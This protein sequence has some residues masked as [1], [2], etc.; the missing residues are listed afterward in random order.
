MRRAAV[1]KEYGEPLEIEQKESL[2]PPAD[3]IV[4]RTEACGI[5]RSD[6][7]G[8]KGH[9]PGHPPEG[10]VLGHE[11]AGTIVDV[12]DQ[13][14][15]FD[16]GD[17]VGVP[18][19]VACGQ[20]EYCWDGRSHVCKDRKSIGLG[21][22]LPGAFASEFAI[23]NADFNVSHLPDGMSSI[24]MAALGCRYATSFHALA[25]QAEI[26]GGEWVVVH[27]CGGIGLSAVQIAS[28]LGTNVIAVD[29]N[30][31]ALSLAG[32]AGAVET[33]NPTEVND[34]PNAISDITNGGADISV[35]ALGIE[36]TCQNSVSSVATGGQHLQIG[37]T[38]TDDRMV[39][40]PINDITGNEIEFIGAKGMP[41]HRY[42]EL[43]NLISHGKLSP[44]DLVSRTVS[45]E[46]VSDR[47]EAMDRFENVGI[48]V[49]TEF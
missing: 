33:I 38:S 1:F 8:W 10:H 48:E 3:G 11:P 5:C 47:L 40:L 15:Q 46:E 2:D 19:S 17:P 9:W 14:E 13:V 12:G 49:I 32:T 30:D 29:I 23:P 31:E 20:C 43:L 22:E 41:V 21:A 16:I 28:V 25:H 7:H 36:E 44:R 27:G 24:E 35:D 45:L 39:D 42:D 26:T 37:M 18:F 6:W 34:V 4:V